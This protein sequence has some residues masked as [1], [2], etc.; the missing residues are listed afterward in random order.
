MKTIQEIKDF[1][2]EIDEPIHGDF[3]ELP[4]GAY[5]EN[6]E[7][8]IDQSNPFQSIFNLIENGEGFGRK[9]YM[10][11]FGVY[12]LCKRFAID[13]A[14]ELARIEKISI[15]NLNE[16]VLAFLLCKDLQLKELNSQKKLIEDFFNN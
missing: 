15:E 11:T 5:L 9:E 16:E 13:E 8:L 4:L 1:F 2:D 14:L 3:C 6:R 7:H 12:Y 10:K